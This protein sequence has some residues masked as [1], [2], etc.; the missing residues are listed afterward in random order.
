MVVATILVIIV[1]FSPLVITRPVDAVRTVGPTWDRTYLPVD[2]GKGSVE[3]TTSGGF[4]ISALSRFGG[5][6]AM[7]ANA[8]GMP[9]WQ[10]EYTPAEYSLCCDSTTHT[11]RQ[12]S[13]GGYI[14]IGTALSAGYVTGFDGWILKLNHKGSVEWSKTYG[15]TNDDVL[16]SGGQ[17]SDGGYVVAG[18]TQSFGSPGRNSNGW[19]LKLD[20]E[21]IIVWQEAFGGQEVHSVDQT[22][23]GGFIAAGTV[24]V[25]GEADPWLVKLDSGG[26]VEWQK[27]YDF[28]TSSDGR[29]IQGAYSAH[30]TTDGGYIAVGE[31]ITLEPAGGFLASVTVILRVDHDGDILWLDSYSGG[32][33]ATPSSVE[34]GSDGGFI[35]AGRFMQGYAGFGGPLIGISGPWLLRLDYSGDLLWQKIYGRENDLLLQAQQ[36]K[37]GGIIA[38]GSMVGSAPNCCDNL[39]WALKLDANGSIRG[40]PVGVPSNATMTDIDSIVVDTAMMPVDTN[41][42]VTP[43]DVTVT[44]PTFHTRDQC[45]ALPNKNESQ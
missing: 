3:Q 31:K 21:G 25:A 16:V 44:T 39:A 36:T 37:D 38:V 1:F 35:I 27:A 14:V 18:N 12:T 7:K 33:R 30:Q 9:E 19:L 5:L 11:V 29:L 17:T 10:R 22:S 40:C 8:A 4:I 20:P 2:F 45:T 13:D 24:G 43:V 15:G 34:Q 23:D 32:G 6:W 42:T 41:A 28:R 26:Q